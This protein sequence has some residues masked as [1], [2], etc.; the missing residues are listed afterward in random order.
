MK[1]SS[2]EIRLWIIGLGNRQRRDDGVGVRL[3]EAIEPD[4][5]EGVACRI[6]GDSDALT[7]A[8]EL[9]EISCPVLFVDGAR[10]G[11]N[12]GEWRVF[13]EDSVLFRESSRA[14]ST[15]G[16]GLDYA[17]ELA[18]GLG[19]QQPVRFFAV[20]PGELQIGE[21]LSAALSGRFDRLAQA[22]SDTVATMYIESTHDPG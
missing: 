2:G 8:H 13:A 7:I 9:I 20:Q 14:L 15:H 1:P 22:L 18:R 11:L 12:V 6:W 16:Y 3:V 19:F 10:M 4:V 17:L 21:G 5:A